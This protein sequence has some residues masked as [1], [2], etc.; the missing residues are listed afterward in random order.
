LDVKEDGETA[1]LGAAV[2]FFPGIGTA[3]GLLGG[4]VLGGTAGA[5]YNRMHFLAGRRAWR[6]D[7]GVIFGLAS[8]NFAGTAFHAHVFSIMTILKRSARSWL[9]RR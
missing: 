6:I 9:G 3:L 2:I 4:A 8:D 1:G 5:H 7:N